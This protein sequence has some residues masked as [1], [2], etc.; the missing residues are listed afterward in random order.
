MDNE[1]NESNADSV[2]W[3]LTADKELFGMWDEKVRAATIFGGQFP[4][5]FGRH[6]ISSGRDGFPS[7]ASYPDNFHTAWIV[8]FRN[9]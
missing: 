2:L 9:Y 8:R 4:A 7:S 6:L 5:Q 1:W 3:M